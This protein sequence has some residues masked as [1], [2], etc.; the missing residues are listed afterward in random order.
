[1]EAYAGVEHKVDFSTIET[2]MEE[3][4]YIW[5]GFIRDMGY[6]VNNAVEAFEVSICYFDQKSIL[7]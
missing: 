4:D 6:I 3:K 5:K 2:A 1:M 7:S